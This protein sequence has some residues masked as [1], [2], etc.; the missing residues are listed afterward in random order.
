MEEL[1]FLN[2]A[3]NEDLLTL[4]DIVC[5]DKNGDL[6][7]TESLSET[8]AY[9]LYYP[10]DI[11]K[12]LPSLIKEFRLFGGNSIANKLR[13]GGPSYSEILRDV[14]KHCKVNFN[15]ATP[16]ELVEQYLLQKL[17]ND[18]LEKMSDDDLKILM[19]EMGLDETNF[20]RQIAVSSIMLLW[21]SGGFKSYILLVSVVNAIVKA[22]IGRGLSLAANA[23]MTR[24]A[25]IL[26]G[27]I[28]WV[29]TA[30]WTIIDIAG[31]AYRVTVPAV[32]QIAYI[33][34]VV[35]NKESIKLLNK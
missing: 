30:L 3:S 10:D 13:G 24:V 21:K 31:P 12:M 6:R 26:T 8:V 28:G 34:Y 19:N 32:I 14:A 1:E 9:K 20:N 5:K 25:A 17:F 27:P 33:R 18:S 23:A 11:Q 35:T 22:V 16:N 7:L 29:L 4:C 2:K 15:S